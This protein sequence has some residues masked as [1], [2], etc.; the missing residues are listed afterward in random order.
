MIN[1]KKII[2]FLIIF[3]FFS[4]ETSAAIKDSLFATI[5]S[6][7]ITRSDILTEIKT[8]LILNGQTYS[9]DQK[10]AIQAAAI[11]STI[12]RSIKKIEVEKYDSLEFSSSDLNNQLIKYA[13]NLNTDLQ[14]LKS[15]FEA[16]EINFDIIVDQVKTELLWNSLIF[17]LYNKR[18]TINQIEIDE[19]L[20][21]FQ[22]T[23]VVVEYLVSEIIIA[24]VSTG[25]LETKIAEIKNQI[26]TQGFE[27]VAMNLSISETAIK[28]GNLGWISENLITKEFK[29]KIIE[30][31][32]GEISKPVFLPQ[33]ILFFQVKDKRKIKKFE[34]LEEAKNDLV[35]AEKK[36]ILNMHSLSHYDN[37]KR[38]TTINYY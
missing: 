1:L 21:L 25:E 20:K 29:E 34:N 27:T 35:Q 14:T 19:Q 33:G 28:G 4:A 26:K 32:I 11:Q 38:S 18:L 16:N 22:N 13:S 24:K 15:I 3:T 31:P 8:I 12:R 9:E 7:A 17:S 37:L 36:K 2:Y 5:G 30:T 6:K 23:Q 10:D